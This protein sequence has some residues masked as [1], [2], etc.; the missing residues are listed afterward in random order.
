[1]PRSVSRGRA[2]AAGCAAAALTTAVLLPAAP[3]GAVTSVPAGNGATWQIHDASPPGLD[4]GSIRAVSNS[5]VEGFGNIFVRVSIP[6]GA[7]EPRLNGEMMRGFGLTFDGVDTFE[8]TRSVQLGDVRITREVT[9]D[10]ADAWARF[11]DTF[12]N[13]GRKPV[14]VEVSFGG[15]LGFGAA[16]SQGAIR[17]TSSGD[18]VVDRQDAWTLAATPNAAQRPVGVVLGSPGAP[19]TLDRTGNQQ[20]DPFDTPMATTGH[21]ANFQG[22]VSTFTVAPRETRSLARFVTVG[23]T[24]AGSQTAAAAQL[25]ALAATPDLSGLTTLERCTLQNWDASALGVARCPSAPVLATPSAGPQVPAYTTSSYDVVNTSIDQMLRDLDAGVTTSAEIT[26]AYLDRI[27]VYDGGP[28][29]YHAFIHVAEDAMQQ[30]R[31]ADR[32]RARGATGELLGIPLAIKDLYD[33]KDMPTTGGTLALEGWQPETDAYQVER[34]RAAGAV[35]IGKANLSEFANSGGYSESGWGQ[36]WNALYPSKTSFGSSGGSAV[37]VATSMAAGAL[38]SQT[39][40]SLYAPSTGNSLT[41][42]RGTDGMASLRGIMPLTWAQDYG[43]PIARSVTDLAHL[44]NATTGTDPL[45]PLTAQ[46]DARRP[47]DWTAHLDAGALDGMRIGYLPASFVSG[48]ADDGTG[49]AVM[50]HFAD[51]EAAGATMVE[52]TPPPSGGSSPGGSRSE[53]GWARYIE[54]HDDFPYPDGDALLASPLVLPYNQRALRD[55]PRMTPEQVDAWLAYRATYKQVIAGWMDAADVDA[56]VYPGFISD[57]YNNDA[58]GNQLTADRGTGVLTSNVGLPTV[59]VPVGTNPHGYSISMQLVGRAW[60]D[61]AIL[62]MG[63][64]LEQQAQGQQV[65]DDAPALEYRPNAR[66]HAVPEIS[67]L[68]PGR[69]P[70]AAGLRFSFGAG[71]GLS[72]RENDG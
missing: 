70:A 35:I 51:L 29:G 9:V 72:Q 11:F 21:E 63:Y 50:E 26:R 46:A 17:S 18:A 41:T 52:L 49:A 24:G 7:E 60:D 25:T 2:V 37:A 12:T 23:A 8:P 5:P 66:P 10:G 58:A 33:T 31:A 69:A 47:A 38:G 68:V 15:S 56:V 61:A 55:T 42:F 28:L 6:A 32:A 48:Y 71:T 67:P 40:V 62:G 43:G 1:M 4:T 39:G 57:M 45:D 27:A 59:V 44:L 13:T 30:A 34:L 65:P 16:Q 20:R 3:T 14:T 54:L 22:Y 36:V 53:E 19:G 64:A